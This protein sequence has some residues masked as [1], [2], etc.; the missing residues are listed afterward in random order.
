M[1][2]RDGGAIVRMAQFRIITPKGGNIAADFVDDGVLAKG[3]DMHFGQLALD[4]QTG[5]EADA[6]STLA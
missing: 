1:S 6:I 3:Y 5:A 4:L 2:E